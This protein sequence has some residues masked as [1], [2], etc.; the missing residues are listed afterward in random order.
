MRTTAV[1]LCLA[2]LSCKST[3]VTKPPQSPQTAA[4]PASPANPPATQVTGAQPQ[5]PE[6][7]GQQGTPPV[8]AEQQETSAGLAR[9]APPPGMMY[10]ASPNGCSR[11]SKTGYSGRTGIYE[12]LLV[13]DEIRQHALKNTDS[14]Q[15]KRAAIAKGMRTLRND[16]ALKVMAGITTIEEVLLVTAEDRV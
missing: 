7:A 3:P 11:C 13:D 2:I 9:K 8:P 10:K 12:L 14:T 1:L 16:G 6:T 15:I 5:T 4:G